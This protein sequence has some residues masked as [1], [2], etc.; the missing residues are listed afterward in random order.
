MLLVLSSIAGPTAVIIVV[1]ADASGI[2]QIAVGLDPGVGL[3]ANH[4][5]WQPA[6]LFQ[7][8]SGECPSS[9]DRKSVV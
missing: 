5:T 9:Q 7:Q 3:S 2:P 1:L 8:S 6:L 4:V